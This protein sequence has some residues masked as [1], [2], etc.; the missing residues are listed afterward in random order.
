MPAGRTCAASIVPRSIVATSPDVRSCGATARAASGWRGFGPH[1]C[2]Q[3]ADAGVALRLAT[4]EVNALWRASP[5]TY[6][7][8]F[9]LCHGAGGLAD[10]FVAA[11]SELGNGTWL[12]AAAA[13]I[14]AGLAA[15]AGG[16]PWICGVPDGTDSPSLMLGLAGTG[17]ALLRL[18]DPGSIASPL[19]I[20][21]VSVTDTLS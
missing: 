8:N 5:G 2:S 7:S 12:G 17:T 6:A 4:L 18:A 14:Q 3:E 11:A 16:A 19:T 13:V 10:M 15:R 20:A 21:P 1:D 9:S